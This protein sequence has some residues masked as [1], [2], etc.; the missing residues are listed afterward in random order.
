L[1]VLS[2]Q[3]KCLSKKRIPDTIPN[4]NRAEVIMKAR[5]Y[6]AI[7][8]VA[9]TAPLAARPADPPA[10]TEATPPEVAEAEPPPER[11]ICHTTQITGSLTRRARICLTESQWREVHSRTK[12]GLDE[13]NRGASGG[14]MAPTGGNTVCGS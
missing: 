2:I 7:L 6:G 9:S 12:R 4:A 11:K 14:C 1:R 10:T 8:L 13:F 5:L 3:V